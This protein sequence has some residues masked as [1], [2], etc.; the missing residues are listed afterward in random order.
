[1]LRLA[2]PL[3][4]LFSTSA[5]AQELVQFQNG[6]VAD[7]DDINSNFQLLGNS[8]ENTGLVWRDANGRLLGHLAPAISNKTST[9]RVAHTIDGSKKLYF[10]P[11]DALR[12][13]CQGST[14]VYYE[15]SNCTGTAYLYDD[16]GWFLAQG[17][18]GFLLAPMQ[19]LWANALTTR[20]RADGQTSCTP[21][22]I[23]HSNNW[24]AND[25]FLW[26]ASKTDIP[27]DLGAALP[28][29]IHKQ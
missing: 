10:G 1:M 9:E 3:L 4:L 6:Q 21:I 12:A 19:K 7:A 27:N 17:V 5:P 29:A 24:D 16:Q 25:H 18:E 23:S 11:Y 15:Y 28:I 20:S 22:C 2:L 8:I 26:E 13:N 14:T